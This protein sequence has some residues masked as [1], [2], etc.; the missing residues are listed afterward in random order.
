MNRFYERIMNSAPHVP[1]QALPCPH[2]KGKGKQA[3]QKRRE[4]PPSLEGDESPDPLLGE[5]V[6]VPYTDGVYP[7]VVTSVAAGAGG[8]ECGS[9]AQGKRRCFA[10]R[11]I[12]CMP[13]ML[14]Q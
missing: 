1:D 11:G 14:Q 8:G 7:G 4:E 3:Q 9:N 10:L 5:Q 13:V 6:Y 2:G 12:R